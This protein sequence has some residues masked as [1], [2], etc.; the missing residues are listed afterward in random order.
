MLNHEPTEVM[1]SKLMER[2]KRYD[3][4]ARLC[5]VGVTT[6]RVPSDDERNVRVCF[7][8]TSSSARYVG[9]PLTKA[10]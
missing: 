10:S 4:V 6:R 3:S 1:S 8:R 9:L 2:R 5:R 7:F